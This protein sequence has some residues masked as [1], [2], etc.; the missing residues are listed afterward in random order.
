MKILT[1]LAFTALVSFASAQAQ[2]NLSQA[3]TQNFDTLVNTGTASVT[4]TNNVTLPG[5]YANRQSVGDITSYNASTG[6]QTGNISSF[7]LD[8]DTDRA[9]GTGLNLGTGDSINFG[10][11]FTNGTGSSIDSVAVAYDGEQWQRMSNLSEGSDSLTFS[12]QIFNAGTGSI[13][14]ASGWNAVDALTFT[15]PVNVGTGFESLN[16]NL[17]ANRMANINAIFTGVSLA[18]NQELWIRW[19][20]TNLPTLNDHSLAVD[21][22]TVTFGVVPEPATYATFASVGVLVCAV[23]RRRRPAT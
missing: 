10:V 8:G 1:P 7:G 23:F 6:P 13:S 18:P 21:N 17:P 19:T 12:Y 15:S 5:W 22:L 2:I 9:L 4:W 11:Q 3:Y 14:A 20:A 16:G